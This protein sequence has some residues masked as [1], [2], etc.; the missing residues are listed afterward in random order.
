LTQLELSQRRELQLGK[1][2]HEIWLWGIFS[3]KVGGP[4]VGGAIPGL[5]VLV[6]VREETEQARESRPVKNI[7]P[8]PLHQLLLPDL[9]EFQS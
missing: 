2:L 4:M 6:S 9:L 7:P 8:R 1:C 3:I 5:I